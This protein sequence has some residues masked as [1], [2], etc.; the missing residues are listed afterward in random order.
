MRELSKE[1]Q[2]EFQERLDAID[3]KQ[4][5]VESAVEELNDK[6]LAAVNA[7]IVALNSA[8]SDIREFRDNIVAQISDYYDERTEK[9]QEGETGQQFTRWK[10]AWECEEFDDIE[11]LEPIEVGNAIDVEGIM[12]PMAASDA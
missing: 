9:W 12:L 7:A 6:A 4:K 3:E 8:M 5:A 11:E 1:D 2:K 10:D